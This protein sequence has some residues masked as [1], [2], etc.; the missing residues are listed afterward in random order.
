MSDRGWV[1]G[2][3]LRLYAEPEAGEGFRMPRR[4]APGE[5]ELAA[6]PNEDVRNKG[7][8]GKV[9]FAGR[10]EAEAFAE[11]ALVAGVGGCMEAYECPRGGHWHLQD[12]EKRRD[13]LRRYGLL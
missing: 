7:N 6:H 1:I 4:C 5:E 10:R 9:V 13:R 12:A 11:A 2:D 8:T 3:L